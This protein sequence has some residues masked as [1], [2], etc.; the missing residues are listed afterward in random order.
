MRKLLLILLL[1]PVL[2]LANDKVLTNKGQ[3]D[4]QGGQSG[5][6]FTLTSSE[7]DICVMPSSDGVDGYLLGSEHTLFNSTF[8]TVVAGSGVTG[9]LILPGY[10]VQV[11]NG[12]ITQIQIIP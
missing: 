5:E 2:L 4:W 7:H 10:Q 11:Q 3:Q 9:V 6:H 12:I 8:Q 1:I